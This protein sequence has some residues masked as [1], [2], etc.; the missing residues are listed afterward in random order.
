MTTEIVRTCPRCRETKVAAGFSRD[1]QARDGLRSH[2]KACANANRRKS[3]WKDPAKARALSLAYNKAKG[4]EHIA[5]VRAWQT[6]NPDKVK[7]NKAR[8]YAKSEA[9]EKRRV[10][11][12]EWRRKNPDKVTAKTQRYR[13]RRQAATIEHVDYAAILLRDGYHCYLCDQA[14]A[15]EQLSFDHVVA[16]SRGG[17]ES[18]GNIRV[19]HR[20]CNSRKGARPW[21]PIS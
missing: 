6:A 8:Y 18:A 12:R 19:A 5:K 16:L 17:K 2:C 4:A 9:K 15:P 14:V 20:V 10:Y 1:S 21:P 13:A 11:L 7:A 3:Y